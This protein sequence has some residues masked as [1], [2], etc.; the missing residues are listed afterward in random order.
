MTTLEKDG[1]AVKAVPY[2][3][4]NGEWPAKR[5]ELPRLDPE[6]AIAAAKRLYRKATGKAWPG[7]WKL[8]SGNRFTWPRLDIYYVNAE[9]GWWQLVHDISHR[10]HQ[11]LNPSKRPHDWTHAFIERDLIQHVVSSGWLN[12]KLKKAPTVAD[13]RT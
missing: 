9:A 7:K 2:A 13:K 6:E 5:N 3:H 8:T 10:A 4:V 11:R 12:G 1:V